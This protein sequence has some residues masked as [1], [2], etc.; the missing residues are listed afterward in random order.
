MEIWNRRGRT[1]CSIQQR[2]G[3]QMSSIWC[4]SAHDCVS[5]HIP[6]ASCPWIT[7]TRS[8]SRRSGYICDASIFRTV[9]PF[10]IGQKANL[11]E[12]LLLPPSLDS[13]CRREGLDLVHIISNLATHKHRAINTLRALMK[14]GLLEDH[15]ARSGDS[16]MSGPFISARPVSH[17]PSHCVS[18]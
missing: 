10:Q 8:H 5:F 14:R 17:S 9:W 1:S 4:H 12:W 15:A 2:A 6:P 18:N 3:L 16:W 7:R 13:Q 11:L